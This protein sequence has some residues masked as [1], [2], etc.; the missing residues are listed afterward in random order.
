M[1][2]FAVQFPDYPI[3]QLPDLE[4][5]PPLRFYPTSSHSSQFG[6]D[7]S[8]FPSQRSCFWRSLCLSPVPLPWLIADCCLLPLALALAV[9]LQITN[10]KSLITTYKSPFTIAH[11]PR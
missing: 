7:F 2:G 8:E 10:H 9:A 5:P 3:T 11:F 4:A 6:V 1:C